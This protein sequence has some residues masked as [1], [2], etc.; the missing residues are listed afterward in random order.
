ML[1]AREIGYVYGSNAPTRMALEQPHDKFFKE[2][3]SNPVILADFAQAFLPP[4]VVSQLDFSTLQRENETYL[5][6]ALNE[7]F[8]DLLFTISYGDLPIQLALLFEHKSYVEAYPHFQIN[9]YLLNFWNRQVKNGKPLVPVLPILVY[10]GDRPWVSQPVT[11][12]FPDLPTSLHPYVPA[13]EYVLINL[14]DV[15]KTGL[16]LLRTDYARLTTLL[17][18]H[19]RNQKR[20]LRVF[21]EFAYLFERLAEEPAGKNFIDASFLY[22]YWT[23]DLT[24]TQVVTIFQK[25][26]RPVGE[27]VMTTAERLINEG[28]EKGIERGIERGIDITN[29]RHVKGL[30]TMGMDA[31][32]IATALDLPVSAVNDIISKIRSEN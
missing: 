2:T 15:A 23:T 12:Y 22:I 24:K 1:K 10:H 20:L 4:D 29:A 21:D 13:F 31:N 27:S 8:V 3:F 17:L 16:S 11:A 14:G 6:P 30:F 19:S 18:R 9:Q 32:T 26:S 5:D 25:I 28:V 7:Y